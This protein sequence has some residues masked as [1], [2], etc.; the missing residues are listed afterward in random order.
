MTAIVLIALV[1]LLAPLS[2]VF[3]SDSRDRD[4][5]HRSGWRRAD[6]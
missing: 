6:D 5:R 4:P 2:L 3:G 1:L